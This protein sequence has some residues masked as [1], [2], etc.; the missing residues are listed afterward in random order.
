M[1][2]RPNRGPYVVGVLNGDVDN[3]ADLKAAHGLRIA[4]P[5]TTDAKVIPA[6]VARN[7]QVT[8]DDRDGIVEAFRRAVASFDGSVAIGAATQCTP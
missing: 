5:I 8:G 1:P 6:L 7:A 2:R 4:G 3:H